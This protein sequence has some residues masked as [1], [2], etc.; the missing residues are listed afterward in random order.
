MIVPP[1]GFVVAMALTVQSAGTPQAA[2]MQHE[3]HR[4]FLYYIHCACY[5]RFAAAGTNGAAAEAIY[6][7]EQSWGLYQLAE[8]HF[9][10]SNMMLNFLL[11]RFLIA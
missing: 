9:Y 8:Q 2:E 1:T 4:H 5:Q 11:L 10:L 3:Q 7:V 6:D